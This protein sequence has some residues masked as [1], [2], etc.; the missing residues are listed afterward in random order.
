MNRQE[1]AKNIYSSSYITGNFTLRSGVV[2]NE[3][4]DKYRFESDPT[5]LKEIALAMSSLIANEF[6]KYDYLGALEMGGIPL[7][8][9][10]SLVNGSNLVFIRKEA[11]DYGT[12]K[13]AEGPDIIDKRILLIED[14]VTSGGQ[15]IKSAAM[16]RKAGAI[17]DTALCVIDREAGGAEKL[18]DV[19]ISMHSV[20][21]M[22]EL[23]KYGQ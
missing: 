12:S 23:K 10:L 15:I 20:F 3:Y 2:S 22:S 18:R 1:L 5:I 7:A 8:V 11:K 21:T 6:I 14:V 16:L 13:F 4:F 17:V 9:S 19:D